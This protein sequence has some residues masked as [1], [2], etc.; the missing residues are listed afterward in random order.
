MPTF[1]NIAL[2]GASGNIGQIFLP[3]LL[4]SDFNVTV[5][6]R[7]S[8]N[9]TF[10]AGA[11]VRKSDF[12]SADLE[13]AFKGQDVV[14]SAVGVTGF[15][16]QKK[17]VD[18]AIQ[19]G[20][21]R[22]LPSEFSI[23]SLND[24]VLRILP[25]F[26]QKKD[27]IEYLKSKQSDSF[28]WTGV[29]TSGLFDWGIGFLGFD[30][31]SRSATIWDGGNKKFTLTNQKQ[32]GEAVV[33]VLRRPEVSANQHLYI[34]SV[35]TTQNEILAALESSTSSSWTVQHTTTDA[36]IR[37]ANEKLQA[38]DFNGAVTLALAAIYGDIPGL[39]ANFAKDHTLANNVLGLKDESVQETIKRVVSESK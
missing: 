23:D 10:P 13:E 9:A 16:E 18:A 8:S 34:S 2:V 36:Q 33:S 5:L 12:S 11:T 28:S 31:A 14:I 29:V 22:F 24:A 19:A 17:L 7:S 35:E 4:E 26:G 25:L 6:T 30:L 38:G 21:S 32:L 15:A 37:E 3:F 1:K 20:V 27:V 39:Q